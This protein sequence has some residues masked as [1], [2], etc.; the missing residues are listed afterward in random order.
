MLTSFFSKSKPL[1]LSLIILLMIGFYLSATFFSLKGLGFS[2]ILELTGV[3]LALILNVLVLNFIAKKNELTK[4]SAYKTLLFTIFCVSFFSL[5][6]NGPAIIANLFV[7][8]A[9][10][11][12]I[13]LRTRKFIQQKIFDATFWIGIA[14]LYYFWASLFFIIVFFAILSFAAYF[15]NWL[16]PFVAFLAVVSLTTCF[17]LLVNDQFYTFSDWFQAS[18][19]DFSEYRNFRLLIP[20]SILLALLLWTLINYFSALQKASV[21]RR[22]VLSLILL[23]LLVAGAVAVLA[24]TKNGS[25]LIFFFVPFSIIASNYFEGKKEKLFKEI[26]LTV[27]ILMPFVLAFLA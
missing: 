12:I 10:R 16:V 6:K 21:T 9:L 20:L 23:Y 19:F 26:L 2:T 25:E 11:R 17:H 13:S 22:P 1:N 14:S 7:L 8:L 27:L 5:L 15:K 24:P 3:L 4:R 18:N